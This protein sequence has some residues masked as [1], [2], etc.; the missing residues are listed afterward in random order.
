MCPPL[1]LARGPFEDRQLTTPAA[2]SFLAIPFANSNRPVAI[3]V[4]KAILYGNKVNG[5]GE[6]NIIQKVQTVCG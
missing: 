2:S 5:V 4:N 1:D 3:Q 6:N